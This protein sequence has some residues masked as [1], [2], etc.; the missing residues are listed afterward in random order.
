MRI[1]HGDIFTLSR[2]LLYTNNRP[3]GLTD[4]TSVQIY[5]KLDGSDEYLID[6][7]ACTIIDASIGSI[8]YRFDGTAST[9][10]YMVKF[11]I[12]WS[13]G[14]TLSVPSN[15]VEWLWIMESV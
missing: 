13:D 1:M 15:N 14:S 3:I 4:A 2:Q 10:F 8:E 11:K 7:D 12:T 9:G 5:V 6:G